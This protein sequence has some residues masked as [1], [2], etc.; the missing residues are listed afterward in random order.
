MQEWTQTFEQNMN[1]DG[2]NNKSANGRK[3]LKHLA[4]NLQDWDTSNSMPNVQL[5]QTTQ[6]RNTTYE[7]NILS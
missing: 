2:D 1:T 4:G 3:V 7:H 5:K 6:Q